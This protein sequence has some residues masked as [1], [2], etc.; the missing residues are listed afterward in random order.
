[1]PTTTA[2]VVQIEAEGYEPWSYSDQATRATEIK[3]DPGRVFGLEV[4]L[5]PLLNPAAEI[6]RVVHR[7]LYDHPVEISHGT[8]VVSPLTP[9]KEDLQRLQRLGDF[10]IKVFGTY[11][12]PSA[13]TLDQQA[14]LSLLYNLGSD[15]AL[16]LLGQFAQKAASPVVRRQA[17]VW[18]AKD[19]RPQDQVLIQ[20]ISM[21][22]SDPEVRESASKLLKKN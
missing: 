12:Q 10:A 17:L 22:D 18:L 5:R 7:T 8:T 11:V 1:V 14:V 15:S 6:T 3:L 21:Q 9:S 2:I 16:D 19:N 4:K 20:N 13:S